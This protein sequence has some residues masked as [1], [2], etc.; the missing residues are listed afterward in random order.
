MSE[1]FPDTRTEQ[2]D[3]GAVRI[4]ARIG[5]NGPPL[6]LLHGFPQ[7]HLMWHP[8]A[9]DLM[10]RF[11]C[12]MPDLRGY[13]QSSCPPNSADNSAYAKREM[14]RDMIAVMAQLGFD[15]FAVV[16]H[17][18]GGRVSYRMALDRPELVKCLAVLD[19]VPTHAM[20]SGMNAKVAMKA[21]H[22]AFLAQPYP[23][24]ETLLEKS[25]L[26]WI[27]HTLAAW[28][29]SKDLSAFHPRALAAYRAMFAEPERIHALC[30]DYRAGATID[31]AIDGADV[32][33]GRRIAAPTLALWGQSGFPSETAGPLATWQ[34]WCERVEGRGIPGGHFIVEENPRDTLAAL[35]PFLDRHGR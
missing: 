23:M 22:W 30:N 28:T 15:R 29:G 32:A 9:R 27:D 35:M 13:G 11:T 17:D 3:V 21:Y 19:I 5:G 8:I 31:L 7:T 1:L 12:V 33:A 24:P 34:E 16:G 18:R 14:A 26:Q 25:A 10:A 4:H 6:L 20:W 2:F